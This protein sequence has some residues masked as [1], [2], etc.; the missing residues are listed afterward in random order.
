MGIG[1]VLGAAAPIAAGYFAGPAGFAGLGAGMGSAVAA[2]ALTGAGIAALSGDDI[3]GGAFTGGLGGMSGGSMGAAAAKTAEAA[4]LA[5]AGAP[6]G[7]INSAMYG[8]SPFTPAGAGAGQ[9]MNAS[10][11]GLKS[12]AG[13]A[14]VPNE[15][16][17]MGGAGGGAGPQQLAQSLQTGQGPNMGFRSLAT[18]VPG[19]GGYQSIGDTFAQ[20]VESGK[21]AFNEPGEFLKNL[22]D[23]SKAMGAG[24]LG[25]TGLGVAG[26]AGAFDQ[27]PI[28]M[29]PRD[30]E[31]YDPNRRLNLNMDTGIS[32]Y[33]GDRDT[34]LRLLA[35]G[36][37]VK[38]YQ[39]GG[40]SSNEAGNFYQNTSFGRV[41]TGPRQIGGSGA[42][43]PLYADPQGRGPAPEYGKVDVGGNFVKTSDKPGEG[44]MSK[45][46][47]EDKYPFKTGETTASQN[48]AGGGDGG[49]DPNLSPGGEQA[50]DKMSPGAISALAQGFARQQTTSPNESVRLGLEALA[51]GGYLETGGKVGDG[52]SDEIKASIDGNQEARLSDGEFVVPADVVS[53]LGNGSSDAGAKRLYEMM[54]KVRT[55]RTGNKQQGKEIK[56]ERYMPR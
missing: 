26:Q 46:E 15:A 25:I 9:T 55:A 42:G 24:K 11:T 35:Q 10:L 29:G 4:K 8:T 51:G 16:L 6:T 3:L 39:V 34:G 45:Q 21:A 30:E 22:G 38:R 50:K 33:L 40:I 14:F 36:G 47:F 49:M 37:E 32:K 12:G 27:E 17:A 53:H 5:Q 13:N 7:S 31:R 54:D 43:T 44:L 20:G 2:G 56:P 23:G 41:Y 48:Q 19:G 52:M 1:R 18:D 28:N